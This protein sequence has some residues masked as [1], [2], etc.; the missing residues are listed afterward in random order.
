MG[1]RKSGKD[2][3]GHISKLLRMGLQGPEE[4]RDEIYC[5]LGKQTTENPSRF[6][7]FLRLLFCEL[8]VV[9]VDRR[10]FFRFATLC[11][12][13]FRCFLFCASFS[14]LSVVHFVSFSVGSLPSF[15][16]FFELFVVLVDRM[17]IILSF[18]NLCDV[19]I[20]AFLSLSAVC[21]SVCFVLFSL[22]TVFLSF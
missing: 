8:F 2:A 17:Q 19:S 9:H 14:L 16:F 13:P 5:Q 21:F 10:P 15:A 7:D 4:L 18:S 12:F 1:D 22:D 20:S 6:V 11:V 3:E